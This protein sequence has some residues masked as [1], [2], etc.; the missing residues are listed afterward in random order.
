MIT[1]QLTQAMLRYAPTPTL[2]AAQC[3]I[4][5]NLKFGWCA[6]H[7]TRLARSLKQPLMIAASAGLVVREHLERRHAECVSDLHFSGLANES[8]NDTRTTVHGKNKSVRHRMS[9]R[10]EALEAACA[11]PVWRVADRIQR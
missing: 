10:G 1:Q 8:H 9:G 11:P 6:I 7:S 5:H 3:R 4:M 2:A